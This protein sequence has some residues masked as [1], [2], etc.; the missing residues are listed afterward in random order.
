MSRH[1]ANRFMNAA[2]VYGSKSSSVQHLDATALYELTAPKTPLEVR[3]EIERMIE[4]G[5]STESPD[6]SGSERSLALLLI[7]ISCI[8]GGASN[9][10]TCKISGHRHSK[11]DAT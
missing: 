2:D 5:D 4:A 8:D 7:G 10:V 6:Q 3:E 11:I 9:C 1:T